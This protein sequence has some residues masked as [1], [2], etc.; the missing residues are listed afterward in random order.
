MAYEVNW[1]IVLG[2]LI[3]VF[4]DIVRWYAIDRS[5]LRSEAGKYSKEYSENVKKVREND[6]KGYFRENYRL[7]ASFLSIHS[8]IQQTI[9]EEKGSDSQA[10]I[11]PETREKLKE[12]MPRFFDA[13]N[14]L[15]DSGY[16]VLL[17]NELGKQIYRYASY[18]NVLNAL[19]QKAE[20]ADIMGDEKLRNM[21]LEIPKMSG[22][23]TNGFR[24]ILGVDSLEVSSLPAS[25][26]N[27]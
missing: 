23:I 20:D 1:D 8:Q 17:P 21:W 24:Y 16:I 25:R 4:I 9:G 27:S 26:E 3:A 14:G 22:Y 7:F 12:L 6:A 13:Y 19:L 15:K 2:V 11:K 10:T 18:L 5:R